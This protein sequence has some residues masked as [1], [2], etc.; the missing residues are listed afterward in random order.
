MCYTIYVILLVKY[1]PTDAPLINELAAS[2]VEIEISPEVYITIRPHGN[3][4]LPE[5]IRA[6]IFTIVLG[7]ISTGMG[8]LV[9]L[10]SGRVA[11]VLLN[12][13]SGKLIVTILFVPSK[14]YLAVYAGDV[15]P[16]N[17]AVNVGRLTIRVYVVE[18]VAV[19]KYVAVF[20]PPLPIKNDVEAPPR[21]IL[22]AETVVTFKELV[23]LTKAFS[24]EYIA[25]SVKEFIFVQS[26]NV[27]YPKGADIPI[28]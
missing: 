15:V 16:K 28:A 23:L 8:K 24:P 6:G 10:N 22:F 12:L 19:V 3:N 1:V 20:K 13:V 18:A 26:L 5:M 4:V 11:P 21:L 27:T 9:D 7:L 14:I 25:G 17:V 2:Q